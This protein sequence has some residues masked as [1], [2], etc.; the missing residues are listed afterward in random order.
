MKIKAAITRFLAH[1]TDGIQASPHTVRAYEGDLMK[2]LLPWAEKQGWS[3]LSQ[4][5]SGL[6]KVELRTY[7][8]ELLVD[9]EKTSVVRRLSCFRAF[10]QYL[11]SQGLIDTDL[12]VKIPLPKISKPLPVFLKIEELGM[13][14]ES[15]QGEDF[16][17][18]RDRAL[19]E[20]MYG[21][22]IRVSEVV[23][24]K[25]SNVDLSQGWVKVIGKGSKERMVPIGK[26][27]VQALQE[28]MK[29]LNETA[30]APIF[31]NTGNRPLTTRGVNDILKR[32]QS[33]AG[34]ERPVSAHGLRHSF[35]T[36]LMAGGADLRVIQE[37]LGHVTLST[38]QKY[39]HLDL[40]RLSEEVLM[41]HPLNKK[42]K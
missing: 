23:T 20:L 36:H 41:H 21:A 38:T 1:L 13:L 31:V 7:I 24:L 25:C 29:F 6:S 9:H 39:T 27:T 17:K 33:Q 15:V 3:T 14:I 26:K 37:M 8:S 11:Y 35:A 16:F 19:I 4:I 12:A 18:L 42:E 40:D 2:G 28:Y 34:L 30:Q 22:G 10:F 5:E 32:R